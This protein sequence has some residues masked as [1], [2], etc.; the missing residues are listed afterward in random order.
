MKTGCFAF[1]LFREVTEYPT[2]K[3]LKYMI[4]Y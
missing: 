1:R 3:V 2:Q 4:T